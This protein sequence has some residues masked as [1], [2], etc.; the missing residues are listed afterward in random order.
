M[1]SSCLRLSHHEQ[2]G[3]VLRYDVLTEANTWGITAPFSKQPRLLCL[4]AR[5]LQLPT[6]YCIFF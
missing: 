4:H 6:H 5:A 3:S 2:L 1:L